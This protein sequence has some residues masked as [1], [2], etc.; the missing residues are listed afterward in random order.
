MQSAAAQLSVREENRLGWNWV[1]FVPLS[2]LV[3]GV[4]EYHTIAHVWRLGVLGYQ[5]WNW[6]ALIS[7]SAYFCLTVMFLS[8]YWPIQGLIAIAAT[9]KSR[10]AGLQKRYF[11]ASLI[12]IMVFLVPFFTDTLTWGSFP[13]NV[14]N[15]GIHRLRLIPFLP[16]PDGQYGE[17]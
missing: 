14:D 4:V 16:W 11:Y 12:T 8:V 17:Y 6:G 9:I 2:L 10:S 3:L 1:W 7:P 5:R 13:F 15:N